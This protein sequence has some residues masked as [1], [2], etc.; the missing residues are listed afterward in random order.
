MAKVMLVTDM[1]VI[2]HRTEGGV[3][4]DSSGQVEFDVS[5]GHPRAV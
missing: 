5:E 1:Q 3:Y 4:D 2:G